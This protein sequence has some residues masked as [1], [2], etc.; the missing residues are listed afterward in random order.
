LFILLSLVECHYVI[1]SFNLWMSKGGHD[2]LHWGGVDWQPKHITFGLFEATN[3]SRQ[4]LTINLI[5]IL[6]TYELKR[7]IVIYVKDEGSN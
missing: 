6:D 7:K 1:G 5:E 2:I 3:I 4:T